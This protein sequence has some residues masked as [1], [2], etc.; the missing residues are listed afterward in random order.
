MGGR[1]YGGSGGGRRRGDAASWLD[2]RSCEGYD[3]I[4]A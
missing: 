4:V 2:L 3:G 1:G